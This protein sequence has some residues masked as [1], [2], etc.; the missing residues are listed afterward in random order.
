[1]MQDRPDTSYH[2]HALAYR[3]L[4]VAVVNSNVGDWA[5]YVGAVP[6]EDYASEQFEVAKTGD[7]CSEAE[8]ALWF[9]TL[10]GRLKWRN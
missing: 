2:W 9:P 3:V 4:A 7:K 5:V 1:M 6:G 10:A 8:A